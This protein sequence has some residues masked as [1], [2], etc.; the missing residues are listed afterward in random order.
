MIAAAKSLHHLM[1]NSGHKELHR[2]GI[3]WGTRDLQALRLRQSA[4]A[5]KRH[6]EEC[7]A[8]LR[9]R[10]SNIVASAVS[11]CAAT[12]FIGRALLAIREWRSRWTGHA[13]VAP[14]RRRLGR[15]GWHATRPRCTGANPGAR[16]SKKGKSTMRQQ[17]SGT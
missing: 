13:D 5:N 1:P 7:R 8:R 3:A 6:A 16:L 15:Q 17:K 10:Q 14:A 9:L 4:S 11:E 2:W 12:I